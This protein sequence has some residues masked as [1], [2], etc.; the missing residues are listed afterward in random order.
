VLLG[1][2]MGS[3]MRILFLA[4]ALLAC[5][6]DPVDDNDPGP[7]PEPEP[8]DHY[9]VSLDGDD[10][11]GDGSADE[12]WR[13]LA[14]ALATVPAGGGF[15]ILLEDGVYDGPTRVER[16][17]ESEVVVRSANPYGATLTNFS[18][19]D[20][21]LF[22]T[23]QGSVRLVFEGLA[24]SNLGST[25][26][27]CSIAAGHMIQLTNVSD[28]TL[29]DS[30]IL[31]SDRMPRCNE[32]IKVNLDDAFFFPTGVR[33]AG[34]FFY[35]PPAVDGREMIDVFEPGELDIVDNIF[36]SD[37]GRD[38]GEAFVRLWGEWG[39]N[40]T[41]KP[42]HH[43]S[44]NIFLNYEGSGDRGFIELGG[45]GTSIYEISEALIENNLFVGSSSTNMLAP[46]VLRGVRTIT[47]RAN[48][49][50]GDLPSTAF[51]TAIGSDGSNPASTE[52]LL[53]NNLL[54]DP[55]GTMTAPWV[56]AFGEVEVE[57]VELDNNLLWNAGSAAPVVDDP[58]LL[59]GDPQLPRDPSGYSLPSWD[60]ELG[61]FVSG[62]ESI[63]AEF[64]R[65]VI[66]LAAI[67]AGSAARNAADASKMPENDI[68]GRPR[69]ANPDVGAFEL[70]PTVR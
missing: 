69:D 39:S 33:F 22:V 30:L 43:I 9:W 29:R 28:F 38:G 70:L 45:E 14:H 52:I 59:S 53:A 47:F 44:R 2:T 41:R 13:H 6:S 35:T 60:P 37:R 5:S 18:T 10:D 58:A 68:L 56:H 11:S 23:H 17:F 8:S 26:S 34:N 3:P 21:I 51:L 24:F 16:G 67:A 40:T 49:V 61:R 20:P 4:S 15:D 50:V 55:A 48:T 64:E 25:R 66:E 36:V 12:P 62:S 31:G 46:V 65:L 57:T 63:R 32:V 1:G 19:N 54:A 7:L 27:A 42:R